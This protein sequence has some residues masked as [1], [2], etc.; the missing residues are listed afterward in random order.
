LSGTETFKRVDALVQVGLRIARSAPSGRFALARIADAI[1]DEWIPHPWGADIAKELR[2]AQKAAVDPVDGKKAEKVLKDAWGRNELSDFDREPV[3]VTAS[4]QVHKGE[5]DGKAVAVK[6]LKPGLAASLRQDL[7]LLDGLLAPLGAAFPAV[8]ARALVR[9]IRERVLE[10]LDLEQEASTQRR[11]HRA[12]KSHPYLSVPQPH[13]SLARE[14][15]CVSDWVDG[16]PITRAPDRDQAAARLLTFVV[17]ATRFG[18]VHAD[19]DPHDVLVRKDG[20]LAILDFGATRTVDSARTD[21][22]AKALEAFVAQDEAGVAGAVA[23]L[24]WLPA[25]HVPGGETLVRHA[26]SPFLDKGPQRLDTA[27]VVA[28][29]DRALERD[30][31]PDLVAVGALSPDDLWP[32]RGIAQGFGVIARVGAT[33]D[34]LQLVRAALRDGWDAEA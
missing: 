23:K 8:D 1:E 3:A 34:W 32:A 18:T 17:G 28:A 16:M 11:F 26:L 10:E 22:C 31:L 2:A 15:V 33:G 9:E 27:A 4:S 30:E 21:L 29:R 5:L 6:I 24:G 7:A 20:T 14:N 19:P 13:T 25:A 12:L